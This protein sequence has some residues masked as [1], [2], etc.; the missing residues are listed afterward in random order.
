M[1]YAT[2][3]L[4]STAGHNLASHLTWILDGN[5][6]SHSPMVGQTPD[7]NTVT[8]AMRL[9]QL[10]HLKPVAEI[11]REVR[12]LVQQLRRVQGQV[13]RWEERVSA[14]TQ[15][16]DVRLRPFALALGRLLA[17]DAVRYRKVGS[18]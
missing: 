5:R 2:L 13:K 6:G 14:T 7:A 15:A 4:E 10:G 12:G 17:A 11:R 8:L 9:L 3:H 16:M 1:G 18:P